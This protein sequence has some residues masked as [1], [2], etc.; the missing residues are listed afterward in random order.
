MATKEKKTRKPRTPVDRSNET[1]AQKFSRLASKRV[2]KAL[3][4]IQNIG[5]LAGGGYERTPEQVK[6]IATLLNDATAGTLARF[7]AV[8]AA[9][10][11]EPALVI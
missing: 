6:R 7:N 10:K 8:Q 11:D 9:K 1:K 4:A 5:N 3:K 2:T